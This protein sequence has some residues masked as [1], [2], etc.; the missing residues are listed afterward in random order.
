MEIFAFI[1]VHLLLPLSLSDTTVVATRV[2]KVEI[3]DLLNDIELLKEIRNE[4]LIVR[5]WELRDPSGS[6]GQQNCEVTSSLF[7]AVSEYGECP[8][9]SLFRLTSVY[10]PKIETVK[11]RK[12]SVAITFKFIDASSAK[13]RR[14]TAIVSLNSV[15]IKP[16]P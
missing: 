15:Q 16:L 3:V 5:I 7:I 11:D 8:E 9:H 6:A 13:I 10:G 14:F 2:E 12:H 1:L 4:E